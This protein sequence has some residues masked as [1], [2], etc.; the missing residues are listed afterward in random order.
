MVLQQFVFLVSLSRDF[1]M[2]KTKLLTI[3]WSLKNWHAKNI[4]V[5][6]TKTFKHMRNLLPNLIQLNFSKQI[7]ANQHLLSL[8]QS[9]PL[10]S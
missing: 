8:K 3:S 9:S 7:R 4:S 6:T 10:L 2:I 5:F 1:R